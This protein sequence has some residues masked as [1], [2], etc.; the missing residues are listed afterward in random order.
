M[1][2]IGTENDWLKANRAASRKEEMDL[3]G[4]GFHSK[5][6]VHKSKMTYTRKVKHKN[7]YDYD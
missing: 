2:K 3:L 5:H 1:M 6:S 4:P 7:R